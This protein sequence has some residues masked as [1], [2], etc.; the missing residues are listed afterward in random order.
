MEEEQLTGLIA[1]S[2]CLRFERTRLLG[3]GSSLQ[4]A[5]VDAPSPRPEAEGCVRLAPELTLT[6]KHA[7]VCALWSLKHQIRSPLL[8]NLP[9][10]TP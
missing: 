1:N 8:I 4:P 10:N 3:A 6:G 5:Q 9:F 2:G 7:P